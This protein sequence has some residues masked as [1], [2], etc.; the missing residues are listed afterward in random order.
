MSQLKQVNG[1]HRVQKST[2]S[3][4]SHNEVFPSHYDLTLTSRGTLSRCLDLLRVCGF[5]CKRRECFSWC[6]ASHMSVLPLITG[7]GCTTTV[8]TIGKPWEAPVHPLCCRQ[9]QTNSGFSQSGV[10]KPKLTIPKLVTISAGTMYQS[11]WLESNPY[12]MRQV[13]A[14]FCITLVVM[15]CISLFSHC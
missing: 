7:G 9:Y 1:G 15:V 4:P 6:P 12:H 14:S 2:F 10:T 11:F 13:L 3:S 8:T 5:L